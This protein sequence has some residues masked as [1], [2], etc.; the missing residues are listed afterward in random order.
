MMKNKKY[1][2]L[3]PTLAIIFGFLLWELIAFLVKKPII[4]SPSLVIYS[5]CTKYAA[6]VGLCLLASLGRVFAG[7]ALAALGGIIC[8]MAAVFS[9]KMEKTIYPIIYLL[10]P[11]P[12]IALLPV[13]LLLFGLGESPKIFLIF[14]ICFFQFALSARDAMKAVPESNRVV[15]KSFGSSNLQEMW[16]LFLPASIPALLG[17]LRLS[18]GTAFS[19]LFFTETFGTQIGMGAFILDAWMRVSYVEMYGGIIVLAV[20]GGSIFGFTDIIQK[21]YTHE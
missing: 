18:L 19:I 15:F 7:V 20:A 2:W 5:L 9:D 17:G 14:L 6:K 21:H 3:S 12:K 16:H 11:I 8:A 10:H 13:V 4:P 1:S